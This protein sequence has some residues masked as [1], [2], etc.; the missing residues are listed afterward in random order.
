MA[1]VQAFSKGN[2]TGSSGS[3]SGQVALNGT[4]AAPHWKALLLLI[5]PGLPSQ[6]WEPGTFIDKQSIA[7]DYPTISLHQFTIKD[8]A[9]HA[10]VIDGTLTS[11]SFT[12]YDLH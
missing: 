8:Y 10:A 6:H 7:L 5:L 3:V 11:R 12:D 9:A 1:T 2:L 4:F